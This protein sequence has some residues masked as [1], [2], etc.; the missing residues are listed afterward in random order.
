LK[1]HNLARDKAESAIQRRILLNMKAVIEIKFEN[2]HDLQEKV[3]CVAI[4]L[5]QQLEFRSHR[6]FEIAPGKYP[7][8]DI[9]TD[10][11]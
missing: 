5:A 10:L 8:I 7:I 11:E 6:Y 1:A 2:E 4:L 9:A 3:D